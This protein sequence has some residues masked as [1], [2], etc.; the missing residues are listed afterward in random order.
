MAPVVIQKELPATNL[1]GPLM[2]VAMAKR[3]LKAVPISGT[4]MS[5]ID[6][7]WY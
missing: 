7:N 1:H 5:V 4:Q 2:K 6:Q 3:I